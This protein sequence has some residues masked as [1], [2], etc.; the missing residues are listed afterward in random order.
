MPV[1]GEPFVGEVIAIGDDWS[2]AFK[3]GETTRRLAD[4]QLVSWGRYRD[5][6]AR[7][8]AVLVD[9]SVI[10]G[11]IVDIQADAVA[12][13][14]DLGGDFV[15]SRNYLCGFVVLPSRD[16]V[17]RDHQLDRIRGDRVETDRVMLAN[18]DTLTGRIQPTNEQNGGCAFGIT[19]FAIVEDRSKRTASIDIADVVSITFAGT[20]R[21]A[22]SAKCLLGFD[23]GTL[24]SAAEIRT[25]DPEHVEITSVS[26]DRFR[27]DRQFWKS[28][29]LIQPMSG[30][31]TYVSDL[32]NIGYK[33][34]P[35]LDREWELGVDR[36]VLG[37][38]LRS[39]GAVFL[40]GLGMHSTSR[41]V[42]NLDRKFRR[43][44]AELTLDGRAGRRG[45]V[46]ARVLLETEAGDGS[47][48]W[49]LAYTSPV[50]RGGEPEVPIS[51]DVAGGTRL[52][53]VVEYAD[54]GDVCDHANWLNTR[55][56]TAG[57][58]PH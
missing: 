20:A 21:V 45:S 27:A 17:E 23:D 47:R 53:L 41:V 30:G 55:L 8:Q 43:F 31:V 42:Y 10:V 25:P 52:A 33:S 54:R 36:N 35:F 15:L 19:E 39:G 58:N 22:R 6:A 50:V 2:V 4:G 40:K 24:L 46:V 1:D 7:T 57:S 29:T 28:L 37:G 56:L 5:N 38:R 48:K 12:I 34:F 32:K 49:G 11:D 13:Q 14:S 26:G 16:P 51:I 18:G 3:V 44:Q 9:G